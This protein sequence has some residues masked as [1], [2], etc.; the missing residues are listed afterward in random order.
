MAEQ[1]IPGRNHRRPRQKPYWDSW[2]RC[3]AAARMVEVAGKTAD[4]RA[5]KV[6]SPVKVKP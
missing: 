1:D 2:G 4:R 5:M 3:S 6:K